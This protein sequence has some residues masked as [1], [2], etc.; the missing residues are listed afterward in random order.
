MK[1]TIAFGGA[2]AAILL[3][4]SVG[5]STAPEKAS[6]REKLDNNADA[7]LKNMKAGDRT[8]AA[9]LE[10]SAGY[11][12]F[13][14]VGKGG[15]IAGAAYG[16][17]QVYDAKGSFLGYSDLKQ[18]TVGAQAGAQAYDELV[19]FKDEAALNKFKSGQFSL[20]ANYSAVLLKAN[21]A[22]AANWND[23]V[24]VIVKPE[25]GAMLEASIGGQKFGFAPDAGTR[26]T[27]VQPARH[28][29]RTTTTIERDADRDRD[30]HTD[31][32]TDVRH[33]TADDHGGIKVRGEIEPTNKD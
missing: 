10:R 19:I 13:P 31:V 7:A 33:D 3:F 8:L 4:G 5:C 9:V 6:T 14:S 32:N 30:I 22:D 20:S 23:G 21:T 24:M 16:R 28:T 18:G 11:A 29:E 27:D 17:G 26:D 15:F 2:L 25:G 1:S 12:I